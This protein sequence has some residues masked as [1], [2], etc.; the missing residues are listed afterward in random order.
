MQTITNTKNTFR[1]LIAYQKA[2]ELAMKIF[3]I[4]KEFPKKEQYDLV[5]QIRRSSRGVCSCMGEGYRKRQYKKYFVNK[6]ADA[7]MENTETQV[8]L[9]FSLSCGYID[10]KTYGQM[11]ANAEEVGRLISYMIGHPEK[12]M[13]LTSKIQTAC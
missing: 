10:Q 7:D 4:T 1:D 9:D 6:L 8:W 2:F 3:Q 12:F 13:P 11:I 5:S